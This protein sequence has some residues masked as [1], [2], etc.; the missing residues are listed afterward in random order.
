MSTPSYKELIAR[1]EGEWLT[2]GPNSG[3]AAGIIFADGLIWSFEQSWY[4]EINSNPLTPIEFLDRYENSNKRG[5]SSAVN[6]LKKKG[7]TSSK[8]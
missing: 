1:S 6:Y 8:K 7:F 3:G 4:P 5:F 2:D